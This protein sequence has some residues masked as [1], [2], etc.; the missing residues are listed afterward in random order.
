MYYFKVQDVNLVLYMGIPFSLCWL[1]PCNFSRFC[2]L[3][4]TWLCKSQWKSLTVPLLLFLKKKNYIPWTQ[5]PNKQVLLVHLNILQ[6]SQL[7][8]HKSKRE[9]LTKETTQW[10]LLKGT[11][12]KKDADTTY[13]RIHSS[14]L[15]TCDVALIKELQ[16]QPWLLILTAGVPLYKLASWVPIFWNPVQSVHILRHGGCIEGHNR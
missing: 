6:F 7:H 2:G 9:L 15:L 3:C 4:E 12:L 16:L 5:C 11:H 8:V 1:H 14:G 10:R 13:S